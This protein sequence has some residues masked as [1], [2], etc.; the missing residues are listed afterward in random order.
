MPTSLTT[1]EVQ[2]RINGILVAPDIYSNK[3]QITIKISE[4]L[5]SGTDITTELRSEQGPCG[6][7]GQAS[8]WRGAWLWPWR[9]GRL[10][11]D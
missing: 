9:V 3:K 8:R 11:I 10:Q 1:A 5:I 6:L 4:V 2:S 7:A